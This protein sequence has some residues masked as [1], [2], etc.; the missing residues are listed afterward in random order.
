[1][2]ALVLDASGP[3]M[4]R[5]FPPVPLMVQVQ[6][7]PMLILGALELSLAIAFIA[8]WKAAPDFKAFR[9]LGIFYL[10]V[11]IEQLTG[12]VGGEDLYWTFRAVAVALLV[13]TAAEAMNVTNRRWTRLFWPLYLFAAIAS[14]V[15]SLAFAH[16][17]S[18]LF[19]QLALA[20]LLVQGFRR[21]DSHDRQIASV[22][23]GYFLVR[24]TLLPSMQKVLGIKSYATVRGW[25][26][27]YT[28][29]TLT[30]LGGATLAIFV[31]ALMR[32]REERQR[33]AAELAAGRAVQQLL[34]AENA[35]RV[36]GFR[37]ESA[38]KPY[39][40]VGGDFFQIVPSCDG[41]L[42]IA[43]GD[44]SGKGMSAAMMVSLLVGTLNAFAE[45]TV[46]PAELLTGLNRRTVGRTRGGFITCLCAHVTQ[47]GLMT[48]SDAGHLPPYLAG[49]EVALD[50]GLPLGIA[51]DTKYS[52]TTLQLEPGDSLTFLS[53]GVVE[54]RNGEGELFG[55]ERTGEIA[56]R[57]VEEIA[58]AA[59]KF[60]QEDDITVLRLE[61]V[62]AAAVVG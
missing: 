5:L 15:P 34:I 24:L 7:T 62:G 20:I 35:P 55:F 11:L 31:R 1:M 13:Q 6:R 27:Q 19:S 60:G 48:V 2:I 47:D 61:F 42:L 32:D 51:D 16:E 23:L 9:T 45:T 14:W 26:W 39:G 12:Y 44:V 41:G 29:I 56:G 30:L 46:S 40:E 22:F 50:G 52:E 53:D 18:V 10:V 21:A 4:S 54:A 43:V 57:S 58:Q 28:T 17:W 33:L 59:Q 25:Q 36:P 49:R 3:L 37:I 8:L 38:Y